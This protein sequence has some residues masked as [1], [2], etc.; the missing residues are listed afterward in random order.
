MEVLCF[1]QSMR[2]GGP[3]HIGQHCLFLGKQA[4]NRLWKPDTSHS[5][6]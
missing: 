6:F 2:A 3:S 5:D 1:T 4:N